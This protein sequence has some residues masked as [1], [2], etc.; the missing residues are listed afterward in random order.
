IDAHL[1]QVGLEQYADAAVAAYSAGMRQR[2]GLAA[3]LLR[4]PQLLLLDEPTSSL[5][6]AGARDVRAIVRNLTKNGAAVLL[7][8]HDMA[9]VEDLCTAA[10]VIDRGRVIFTGAVDNL[11]ALAPSDTYLM[12][13]SDDCAALEP[14]FRRQTI[15]VCRCQDGGLEV[16]AST[17]ALDAYVIAL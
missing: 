9:E 3:A 17:Q 5:D 15:K 1:A 6:P 13:T 7:S 16:T 10:T 8:S 4:S 11:R 14:A 12:R 2:L